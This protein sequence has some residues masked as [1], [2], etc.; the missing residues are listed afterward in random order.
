MA[1]SNRPVLATL[2]DMVIVSR[3]VRLAPRGLVNTEYK[4]RRLEN[5]LLLATINLASAGLWIRIVFSTDP[6]P[7]WIQ[8]KLLS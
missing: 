3:N 2:Y 7:I 4:V 1:T 5:C 6:D 8:I